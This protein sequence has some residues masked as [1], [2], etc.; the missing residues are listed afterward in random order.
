MW[1][2]GGDDAT[3][4]RQLIMTFYGPPGGEAAFLQVVRDELKMH[5]K[6]EIDSLKRSIEKPLTGS[7]EYFK[8]ELNIYEK[9]WNILKFNLEG[10]EEKAY[11]LELVRKRRSTEG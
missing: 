7:I 11:C 10:E 3:N 8:N 5:F 2:L 1:F 6:V 9:N 4:L